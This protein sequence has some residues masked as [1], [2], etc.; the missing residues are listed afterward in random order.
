MNKPRYVAKVTPFGRAAAPWGIQDTR[1]DRFITVRGVGC[2]M[3]QVDALALALSL[4]HP[5]DVK[6]DPQPV[7]PAQILS[8]PV[9]PKAW[10]HCVELA[11]KNREWANQTADNMDWFVTACELSRDMLR[12]YLVTPLQKQAEDQYINFYIRATGVSKA[13]RPV[14]PTARQLWIELTGDTTSKEC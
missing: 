8:M 13:G 4:N 14:D 9:F 1:D 7:L 2:R 5:L 10:A 12:E 3:K 11:Q 6:T